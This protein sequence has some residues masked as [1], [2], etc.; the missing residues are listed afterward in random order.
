MRSAPQSRFLLAIRR[1]KTIVSAETFGFRL[2]GFD[3]H[4]QK[5]RKARG[6]TEG[7]CPASRVTRRPATEGASAREATRPRFPQHRVELAD[8]AAGGS[9]N[10]TKDRPEHEPV[11]DEHTG[12]FKSCSRWIL[13][14]SW[15]GRD[16]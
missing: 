16:E 10:A 13:E 3:F 5:R 12:T 4:R 11:L 14:R 1:I 6:A 8:D 7:R 15:G 2:F 9:A